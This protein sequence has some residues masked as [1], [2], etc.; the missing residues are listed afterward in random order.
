MKNFYVITIIFLICIPC[1]T[2]L[3]ISAPE[4]KKDSILLPDILRDINE[5]E[6][7]FTLPSIKKL[8]LPTGRKLYVIPNDILPLV[9]LDIYFDGGR[10]LETKKNLG[11]HNLL[12][13]VLRESGSKKYPSEKLNDE[14]EF[15]G[16]Y[17]LIRS[18]NEKIHLHTSFLSKD[19][20]KII[21]IIK[22]LL[23]NPN[24]QESVFKKVQKRIIEKI[25]RRNDKPAKIAFRKLREVLF[26][27]GILGK[28]LSVKGINSIPFESLYPLHKRVFSK[29]GMDICLAGDISTDKVINHF[30][31]LSESLYSNT[32]NIRKKIKF[33]IQTDLSSNTFYKNADKKIKYYFIHK[34]VPQSTILL[35][36]FSLHHRHPDYYAA[37]IMNHVLGGSSFN[38]HLFQ[39]IRSEK[40]LAYSVHSFLKPERDYGTFRAFAQTKSESTREVIT[41]MID[42]INQMADKGISTNE[43]NW[44]K[45]SIINKFAFLFTNSRKI[46]NQQY[47]LEENGLMPNYLEN[48]RKNISNVNLDDT[49]LS[50]VKYIK[51]KNTAVIIVGNQ[52]KVLKDLTE[53]R[54]IEILKPD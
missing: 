39:A 5:K 17:L 20:F 7:T 38:S 8:K 26:Q 47:H 52:K 3:I 13:D 53:F 15:I 42:L 10:L 45:E 37:K 35:G 50:A 11:I 29:Q 12:T 23:V 54:E 14:L 19:F 9:Y 49:R 40:G 43:L 34:E 31:I 46:V 48:F 27:G 32:E 41:L 21:A 24:Y 33:K 28:S 30:N 16:A 44:A 2:E 25:M 22:D 4:E 18:S 6:L 36:N 1:N 51:K